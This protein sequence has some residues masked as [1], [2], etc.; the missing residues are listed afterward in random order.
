MSSGALGD[1]ALLGD[2]FQRDGIIRIQTVKP[3]HD[4]EDT[5]GQ[6]T[7]GMFGGIQRAMGALEIIQLLLIHV[8]IAM[9]QHPC[10]LTTSMSMGQLVLL[11][12]IH[13]HHLLYAVTGRL[14]RVSNVTMGIQQTTTAAVPPVRMRCAVTASSRQMSNA[15]TATWSMGT[16]ARAIVH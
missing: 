12:I 6:G 15:T 14:M 16:D 8:Q 1:P 11:V 2:N 3:L 13:L 4:I 9:I 7:V 10:R 5:G